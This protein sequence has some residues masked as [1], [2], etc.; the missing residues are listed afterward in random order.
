MDDAEKV[1]LA[2]IW[3]QVVITVDCPGCTSKASQKCSI[4]KLVPL[5]GFFATP[6]AFLGRLVH[7]PRLDQFAAAP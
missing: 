3:E 7:S 2:A 5:N 4:D 6:K 1:E